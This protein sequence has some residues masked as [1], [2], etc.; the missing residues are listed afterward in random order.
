MVNPQGSNYFIYLLYIISLDV[1]KYIEEI[2][3]MKKLIKAQEQLWDDI[4]NSKME[5]IAV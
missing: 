3:M 2:N 1:I 5:I 4:I